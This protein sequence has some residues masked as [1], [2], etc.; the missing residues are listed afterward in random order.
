M[1][2]KS[3][4]LATL[5]LAGIMAVGAGT[6]A[7]MSDKTDPKTN[8][9]TVGSALTGELKEPLWDG[10]NFTNTDLQ[11]TV[12]TDATKL[13]TNLATNFVAKREIPK[14]PAVANTS[15]GT[16][17][18]IAVTIEYTGAAN[19]AAAIDAFADIDWNTTDWTFNAD[20]TVAYYK[21]PVVAGNKTNTL[22][23]RVLIDADAN[24]NTPADAKTMKDFNIKLTAYLVQKEGSSTPNAAMLE[25]FPNVFGA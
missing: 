11:V 20:Y 25:A 3:T 12:P 23:D 1:K 7:L 22:F 6:Y 13:G 5:A 19:S 18:W 14:D 21:N 10:Q 9:F 15:T 16:D 8:V 4:L 2:K 24:A 17:A